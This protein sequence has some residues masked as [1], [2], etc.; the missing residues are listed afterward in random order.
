ME[1][2]KHE[3]FN[4]Q[5]QLLSVCEYYIKYPSIIKTSRS[6]ITPT[7]VKHGIYKRWVNNVLIN[8]FVYCHGKLIKEIH[9]DSSGFIIKHVEGARGN[10]I[11]Y[12]Y[13]S[14]SNI[15][16]RKL[17]YYR[18]TIK[19]DIY[20]FDDGSISSI[21]QRDDNKYTVVSYN[22]NGDITKI[23]LAFSKSFYRINW[24]I[25]SKILLETK[26]G[27]NQNKKEPLI[28]EKITEEDIKFFILKYS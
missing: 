18:Y 10:C 7:V 19:E 26:D 5:N 23:T 15:P 2:L 17:T 21:S 12:S 27:I 3:I 8:D 9:R 28:F 13:S 4:D 24:S 25:G 16:C 14:S 20:F 1:I 22:K 6:C 11:V